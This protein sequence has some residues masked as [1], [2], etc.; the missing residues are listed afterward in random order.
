[1]DLYERNTHPFIIKIWL[2]DNFEDVG[3]PTWRG[4]ITHV[5]TG[6]RQALQDLDEISR[7]IMPYLEKL[8]VQFGPLWYI[9][10]SLRWLSKVK[11]Q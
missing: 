2:E 7:F 6:E 11:F 1:M 8:G 3:H 5:P 10:Q 4:Y 9:K